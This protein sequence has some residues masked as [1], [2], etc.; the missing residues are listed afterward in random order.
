M[1]RQDLVRIGLARAHDRLFHLGACRNV[2]CKRHQHRLPIR[3]IRRRQQHP[4]RLLPPHFSRRKIRHHHHFAPN[5]LLRRISQRDSRQHL[6][7]F[8]SDIHH[9][10]EQ[11]VRSLHF[12]C[13]FHYANSQLNFREI[14]NRD[15]RA[16]YRRCRRRRSGRSPSRCTR[17]RRATRRRRSRCC[18]RHSTR[19]AN[20][21]FHGFYPLHCFFFLNARK[22][23]FRLT[24]SRAWLKS[25]PLQLID[26]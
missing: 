23:R 13:G 18:G 17:R 19:I 4:V 14:I 25:T 10:F 21:V 12:L 2:L 15:F 16:W 26:P 7:H 20:F 5:K 11:L 24:S 6:P 22:H 3:P 8:I 1:R 9:H